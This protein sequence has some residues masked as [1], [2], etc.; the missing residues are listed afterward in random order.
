MLGSMLL[1]LFSRESNYEVVATTRK[2]ETASKLS[3]LTRSISWRILDV[4]TGGLE[5]V[6]KTLDGVTWAINSIG[7]I[8]PHI[9]DDN[10]REIERATRVNALFPH[11]LARAAEETGCKV[12]Q[13]AT[14]C[15]YSGLKG[16]YLEAD[17][18]D[19]LDVY[20]K[21]KSL[22]EVFSPNVS[23]LRCS[24]IGPEPRKN[25]SLLEWFLGQ[26]RD[27]LVNGFTNQKWNG[28]TTL[29]FSKICV[30]IVANNIVLP[31]TQ[32]VIPTGLVT[33]FDL[34]CTLANSYK[35]VDLKVK[36]AVA[37]V[38]VDRT[39]STLNPELNRKLW[40]AADYD[41]V[42]SIAEMV[43]ELASFNYFFRGTLTRT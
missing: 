27:S 15:V 26:G 22:G 4:E 13:I 28:I 16:S 12:I 24:I 8:K 2:K 11:T 33:K 34:L 30:G 43:S 10:A 37:P 25:S 32:H 40:L 5:E 17:K 42:P 7:I 21:T 1:D 39:L 20:G 3:E 41:H 6:V 35:R 18:H 9:H 19:A 23:H 38:A 14:D 36:P 29:H 31:H